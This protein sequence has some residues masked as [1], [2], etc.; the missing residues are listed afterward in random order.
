[1]ARYLITRKL[2]K[3]LIRMKKNSTK[4]QVKALL[5]QYSWKLTSEEI[6]IT[7]CYFGFFD[8]TIMTAEVIGKM[9]GKDRKYVNRQL[10]N[11]FRKLVGPIQFGPLAA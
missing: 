9:L 5:K 4:Q 1:M 3:I 2:D 11:T 10:N 7:H 6:F 8:H